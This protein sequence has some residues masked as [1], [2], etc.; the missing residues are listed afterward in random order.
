MDCMFAFIFWVASWGRMAYHMSLFI[1]FEMFW[2]LV[3][4]W[5]PDGLWKVILNSFGLW[6]QNGFPD[7]L[8]MFILSSFVLWWQNGFQ[9]VSGSSFRNVFLALVAEWLPRWPLDVHS[10]LFSALV[11]EWLPD[12]LQKFILSYFSLWW[13]SSFPDGLWMF[14]SICSVLW[15]QNRFQIASGSSF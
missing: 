2:A 5:L 13:Q 1:H 12:G 10:Q 8:R 3:A 9:M 6:W 4:E 7:G 14:I 11:A 15:W